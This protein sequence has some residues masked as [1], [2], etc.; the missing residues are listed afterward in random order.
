MKKD[1]RKSLLLVSLFIVFSG[2][3]FVNNALAG[4][5]PPNPTKYSINCSGKKTQN[6]LKKTQNTLMQTASTT[7]PCITGSFYWNDAFMAPPT[8]Y[9][10][11]TYAAYYFI[12]LYNV[13][14]GA[15]F[16]WQI[17][18]PVLDPVTD[19]PTG[20]FSS[21]PWGWVT[22]TRVDQQ[23]WQGAASDGQTKTV[24][25]SCH[26]I[27]GG[28]PA[29]LNNP[30]TTQYPGP[31]EITISYNG[32]LLTTGTFTLVD[33]LA[34]TVSFLFPM[35]SP[36]T[37]TE[38]VWVRLS[39][40]LAVIKAEL[41]A[42]NLV[43]SQSYL[44]TTY[45]GNNPSDAL[46]FNWDTTKYP[47]GDYNLR[48]I[49]YDPYNNN[50]TR[51]L[52][53]TI[54]NNP[55]PRPGSVTPDKMTLTPDPINIATG[56]SYFSSK[57]FSL[58]TRGPKLSLFRKYRS[59]STFSGLF[60]YGWRTDF[61]V[62]LTADRNGNLTIYD[63]EGT[64]IYFTNNSST[65]SASAGNYSTIVKNAD[66]TFTLTDK[67]GIVTHYG[68]NGRLTSRTDRNGNTLTFVYNPAQEGGT[69]IQDAS[70]R[71]IKLYFDRKGH[72]ISAVDPAGKTFQY[73]YDKNGNLV[74]V[75]DPE[76][77]VTNY[78]YDSNH[79]II[80][81]TNANGHNTYYQY[82]TQGRATMNWQDTNVNK[83][84]LI[85]QANNTTVVAD[86]LGNNNTYIF[87]SAGLLISHT[88]PL[89]AVTQQTWDVFL[90]R[91]SITDARNN[92]TTF[93]Y[94]ANGNLIQITDPF[95]NKTN[96]TYTPNFNLISN[97]TDALGNV[98]NFTYDNN[99]NLLSVTDALDNK[100]SFVYDQFGN[101]ITATDS[102]GNSTY[103]NY[104][105]LGHMVQQTDA[106]GN[107]IVFTYE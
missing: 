92:M 87:N 59:F 62:N 63:W 35:F 22:W 90:N 97:K 96:M 21:T 6:T 3:I 75:T 94:D 8:A 51:T 12:S 27:F 14:V 99:G 71:Q 101:V 86:S 64:A 74:S 24:T 19:M 66:N 65:Y 16:T 42:D 4:S 10:S 61:D 28:G 88:D 100:H 77:K 11:S 32:Q 89:G 31:W 76:G 45:N 46:V 72:I 26:G 68:I 106:L 30:P 34:P 43:T 2:L 70:G 80:Q 48:A 23:T 78:Y 107:N 18:N 9:V 79:K 7:D 36:L 95:G 105:T 58:G 93:E 38:L 91:L 81:F 15:V 1:F 40:N 56:E 67:N 60:G 37:G 98:T 82:D 52:G 41:Y 49:A 33:D 84:A 47:D 57:D 20:D 83:V 69:Y 25:G 53:V 102:R 39:D 104:D 5:V 103:F 73:D 44:V 55:V 29:I 13:P 54:A 17:Y 85:Y 50:S